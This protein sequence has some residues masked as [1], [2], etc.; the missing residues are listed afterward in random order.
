MLR[1]GSSDTAVAV[2]LALRPHGEASTSMET[3][4]AHL[5]ARTSTELAA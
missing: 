1:F 4:I 5:E 3:V 2:P